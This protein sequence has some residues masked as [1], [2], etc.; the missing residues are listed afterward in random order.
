[1]KIQQA[2]RTLE[3]AEVEPSL[4]DLAAAAGLSPSHFQRVFK[5][6]VGISPKAYAQSVRTVT[7]AIYEAGYAAPSRAY[8]AASTH[9]GMTPS[10]WRKGGEGVTIRYAIADCSLGKMI[11]GGTA[12]GI[13]M[14]AFDDRPEPLK[15]EL[16]ARFPKADLQ[17][18]EEA[19]NDWLETLLQFIEAPATA[20]DLP[21]DIQGTAFQCRVWD[22]LRKIPAGTTISYAELAQRIGQPTATRAVASACANNKIAVVVPCHRVVGSNGKLTGYRWGVERKRQLIERERR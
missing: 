4:S 3:T 20:C 17:P 10:T 12:R 16:R 13:C 6:Q 7:G 1:M 14:I 9:L 11:V 18:A 15:E 2:C 21:L 22:A 5:A 19:F 8:A